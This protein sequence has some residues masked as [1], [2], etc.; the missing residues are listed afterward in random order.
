MIIVTP[1]PLTGNSVA[2]MNSVT[3]GT[4]KFHRRWHSRKSLKRDEFVE[5]FIL[6]PARC[7]ACVH[8]P[9]DKTF[10]RSKS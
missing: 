10:S 5:F 1:S 2:S 8:K 9:A 7:L 3:F 4:F 6:G